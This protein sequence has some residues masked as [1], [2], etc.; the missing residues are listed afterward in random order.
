MSVS[1]EETLQS[2]FAAIAVLAVTIGGLRCGFI[3]EDVVAVHPA[4]RPQ[5]L[6]GAPPIVEGILNIAGYI[7]PLLDLR[8]RLGLVPDRLRAHQH[9]VELQGRNRHV[10]VRVDRA[11][12]LEVTPGDAIDEVPASGR[13]VMPCGVLRRPD[14]LLVVYDPA[15]FL[16][17]A[18]ADQVEAA[19]QTWPSVPDGA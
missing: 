15:R 8:R 19:L 6:P 12:S 2:D 16:D 14:G 4:A 17:P 7:V 3:A 18:E 9:L 11:E 10:A 1:I 5:P 13:A